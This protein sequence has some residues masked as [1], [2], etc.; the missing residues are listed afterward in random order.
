[1]GNKGATQVDKAYKEWLDQVLKGTGKTEA[2]LNSIPGQ[3]SVE[4]CYEVGLTVEEAVDQYT[5]F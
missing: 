4:S 3:P 5:P 1:M 2:Q